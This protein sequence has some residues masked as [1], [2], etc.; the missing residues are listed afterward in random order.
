MRHV[1][2]AGAALTL[3][4]LLIGAPVLLAVAGRWPDPSRG[5]AVVFTP[6]DGSLLAVVVTVAGWLAWAVFAASVG[7]EV[8]ERVSAGR[9]RF[10]PAVLRAPRALAGVL[11]AAILAGTL[12]RPWSGPPVAAP[13]TAAVV[14]VA[15]PP[16]AAEIDVDHPVPDAADPAH[17]TVYVVQPGDDIWSLAER[18]LGRGDRWPEIAALNPGLDPRLELAPGQPLRLPAGPQQSADKAEPLGP[19]DAPEPSGTNRTVTVRRGDTLWQ[20]A[21]RHLGDPERWPEIY[22]LNTDRIA[23]PDEID[24]GWVLRLPPAKQVAI[25]LESEPPEPSRRELDRVDSL[26]LPHDDRP[27]TEH[28]DSGQAP[29]SHPAVLAGDSAV[30]PALFLLGGVGPLLAAG[31]CGVLGARRE[32]QRWHRPPGRRVLHPASEPA[33][34]ETALRTTADPAGLDRA[35]AALCAVGDH[36]R[37]FGADLPALHLV[38]V[39]PDSIDLRFT[40]DLP[41]APAGFTAT[42]SR[43]W[44]LPATSTLESP[45]G[46]QPYPAVITLGT[47]DEGTWVLLN[48]DA[49]SLGIRGPQPAVAGFTRALALELSA[50]P[51]AGL[52]TVRATGEAGSLLL[53]CGAVTDKPTASEL[54]TELETVTS[55]RAAVMPAEQPSRASGTVDS[56]GP[57]WQPIVY[58]FDAGLTADHRARIESALKTA[59]GVVAILPGLPGR[60]TLTLSG[61]ADRPT[62]VLQPDALRVTAQSLPQSTAAAIADLHE[63]ADSTDT[64]PAPWWDDTPSNVA[65]LTTPA[66]IKEPLVPGPQGVL[67]P[68]LNLLGPIELLGAT[69]TPPTRGLRTCM[70]YCGWLLEHPNA[71][72]AEMAGSLM[73]AESSRR[74]TMSRLRTW[75]GR[76]PENAQYLPD[77]YSG[78]IALHSAVSSDWQQLQ[79]LIAPGINRVH[80]RTLQTALSMVRGAPLADAAPG[81][82]HWAEELRSDMAATLRD[83]GLV[84]GD[85]AL[86]TGDVD[87]ARWAAA[88]A[89]TTCPEDE[90][91]LCLRIRTEHRAGNHREV[92]R[93]VLRITAHARRLGV[94]LDDG[95]VRLLQEVMEGQI[96]ARTVTIG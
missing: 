85:H 77:A 1:R 82:W 55:E 96:R 19:H 71:T 7:A 14:P 34:V 48:L 26:P 90:H 72:G 75:L 17:T 89:L 27:D 28:A 21:E 86:T 91:L 36:C 88:R 24:I 8:V 66:T 12:A 56:D 64:T 47:S 78:R 87:L 69:G 3:L 32:I 45:R 38:E 63:T 29:R 16:R 60:R 57:A 51:W 54:V 43:S 95:T 6:D 50:T 52:L 92:E 25:E 5:W 33:R 40:S 81:Q 73:V 11:L 93:L 44:Q 74:S 61:E 83:I 35:E 18:T 46:D 59:V 49:G 2:A 20:L 30:N 39:G 67:H 23:D 62:A 58:I 76:S 65:I 37:A 15:P 42:T 70:E 94:D 84:L 4:G 13:V 22:R 41:P 80:P 79:I 31:V 68:T 53:A 10:R 9:L